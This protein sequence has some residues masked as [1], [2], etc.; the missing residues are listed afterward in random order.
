[1]DIK[2][3]EQQDEQQQQNENIQSS[4]EIN[5]SISQQESIHKNVEQQTSRSSSTPANGFTSADDQPK[6]IKSGI[7]L[8]IPTH[9]FNNERINSPPPPLSAGIKSMVLFN[10]LLSHINEKEQGRSRST[11]EASRK[12]STTSSISNEKIIDED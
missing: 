8:L 2:N 7:Q 11:S 10:P 6:R 4:I 5:A 3:Y 12:M 1:T 9:D